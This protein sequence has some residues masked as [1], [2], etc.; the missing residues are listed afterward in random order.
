[1]W[2]PTL[3]VIY[4][5][6]EKKHLEFVERDNI[7]PRRSNKDWLQDHMFTEIHEKF[8]CKFRII[9]SEWMLRL[10]DENAWHNNDESKEWTLEKIQ[11]LKEISNLISRA[12]DFWINSILKGYITKFAIEYTKSYSA[13]ERV[14][15]YVPQGI[16]LRELTMW[17][18]MA[19]H[20]CGTMPMSNMES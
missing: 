16:Y 20:D 2:R 8:F 13:L 12:V 10:K 6:L 4:L 18:K 1:M 15:F 19:L 11:Q 3:D 14:F 5:W 9:M 17:I 7:N